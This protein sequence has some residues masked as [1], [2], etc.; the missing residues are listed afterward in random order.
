MGYIA[1]EISYP[2][3]LN[4]RCKDR[5][6]KKDFCLPILEGYRPWKEYSVN[7]NNFLKVGKL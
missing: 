3:W 5:G 1:I 6:K 2:R 7:F 4:F